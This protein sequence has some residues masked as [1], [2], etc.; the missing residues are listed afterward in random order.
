MLSWVPTMEEAVLF[1]RARTV[2]TCLE[3]FGHAMLKGTTLNTTMPTWVDEH[4]ARERP[5]Q[6]VLAQ[7]K[8]GYDKFYTKSMKK[9]KS[10]SWVSGGKGL[11]SSEHFPTRLCQAIA[12]VVVQLA[13]L[14][15][16]QP[17]EVV[18]IG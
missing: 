10:G 13:Q 8:E 11:S 5:K 3:P 12:T 15:K 14:E 18:E 17:Q 7:D 2:R 6:R 16:K 4:L 1:T 9:D